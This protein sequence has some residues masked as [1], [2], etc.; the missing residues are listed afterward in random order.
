[1]SLH[2]EKMSFTNK[3]AERY[4]RALWK[5][6]TDAGC[7]NKIS[8]NMTSISSLLDNA[9]SQQIL[10]TA[11]A[12]KKV[13]FRLIDVLNESIDLSQYVYNFLKLLVKNDRTYLI[14]DICEYYNAFLYEQSGRKKFYI[15]ISDSYEKSDR[16][17]IISKIKEEFSPKA[18]CIFES[19]NSPNF[20]GIRIQHKSR[21]LDYSVESKLSRLLSVMKGER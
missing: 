7:Q 9:E 11:V 1:M 20:Y 16:D 18:E 3:L 8:E 5:V 21:I 15:T 14:Q 6:A 17:S 13:A 2:V 10:K 19:S 12:F 4:V